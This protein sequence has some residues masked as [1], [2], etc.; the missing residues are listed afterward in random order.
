M[1]KVAE[2]MRQKEHQEELQRQTRYFDTTQK[3]D[4]VKQDQYQNVI[5]RRQMRTQ[6]NGNISLNERDE[7]LIVEHG[8]WRRGQK[9]PDEEIWMRIPKGDYT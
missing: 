1:R 2:E 3:S 8:T 7:Q 5:G 4:Y 6:D 9:M